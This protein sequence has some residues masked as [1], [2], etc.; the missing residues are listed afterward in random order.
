MKKKIS[1]HFKF[2]EAIAIC[3]QEGQTFN[4]AER[5]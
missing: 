3:E 5:A 1:P 4:K 2:E